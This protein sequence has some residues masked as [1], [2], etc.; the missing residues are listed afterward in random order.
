MGGRARFD[1]DPRVLALGGELE[2]AS[3]AN[4]K[5][6]K[7]SLVH[8]GAGT[9]LSLAYLGIIP[10]LIPSL[11]LTALVTVVLVAPVVVL[12]LALALMAGPFYLVSRVVR[13]ARRR[14]RREHGGPM[15]PPLAVPM[16]RGS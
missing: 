1:L 2:M 13:R 4:M 5:P 15:V 9:V 11:A 14:R 3:A 16:P 8:A 7:H 6:P 10:G 12:G